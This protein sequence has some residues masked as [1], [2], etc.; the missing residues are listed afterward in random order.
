[1][2]RLC[3][4]ARQRVAT[5]RPPSTTICAGEVLVSGTVKDL[6][7]GAGLS[8]EPRGTHVLKGVPGKWILYRAIA[9]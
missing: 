4:S 8:F 3:R 1:M 6:T 7:A 9:Y 5:V 2:R